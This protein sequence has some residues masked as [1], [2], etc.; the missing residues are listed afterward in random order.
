ML[1]DMGVEA[2]ADA[3]PL[4]YARGRIVAAARIAGVQAHG[5]LLVCG[6]G[7]LPE[8][9]RRARYQGLR[10]ALCIDAA[11]APALNEGFAPSEAEVEQA[12]RV[13]EGRGG[14]GAGRAGRRRHGRRYRGGSGGVQAQ[15]GRSWSGPQRC[16]P[17]R[18]ACPSRRPPSKAEEVAAV[19]HP[20]D[21]HLLGREVVLASYGPFY[22]TD[23]RLI[24]YEVK[25]DRE[26]VEA[27]A[28]AEL[29]G[30]VRGV[31][32]R[33]QTIVLGGA[34]RAPDPPPGP[35]RPAADHL[36]RGGPRRHAGRLPSTGGTTWEF[37]SAAL[38]SKTQRRWRMADD[39]D[40]EARRLMAVAFSPEMR[41]AA[42]PG[43]ARR[44]DGVRR[45]ARPA[46]DAHDARGPPARIA[47]GAGR[48]TGRGLPGPVRPGVSDEAVP[49]P[50][51]GLGG[52]HSRVQV[53]QPRLRPGGP[54]DAGGGPGPP[55]CGPASPGS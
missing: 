3:D 42:P 41:R 51:A 24:R 54:C 45:P 16:G 5:A 48:S 49:G 39:H 8:R 29:D 9:V 40:E 4:L 43:P 17:G 22:A 33:V 23:Q 12:H 19:E 35:G 31:A 13:R 26:Q 53:L 44:C 32:L 55:A 10:G 28:Y 11:D 38:D 18:R 6:G 7:S 21:E 20:L 25:R 36:R 46:V 50:G 14:G 34:R 1:A 30:L 2:S 52:G 47:R 37:R 27:I 15:P